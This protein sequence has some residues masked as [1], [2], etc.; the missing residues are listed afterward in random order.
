[1]V[2]AGCVL[3]TAAFP[4][5]PRFTITRNPRLKLL[6]HRAPNCTQPTPRCRSYGADKRQHHSGR[7]M[8]LNF[9]ALRPHLADFLQCANLMCRGA[10][11]V[12]HA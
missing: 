5:H 7:K 8:H 2:E 12:P 4:I 6:Q 3:D 11:L 9:T 10:R 1:M